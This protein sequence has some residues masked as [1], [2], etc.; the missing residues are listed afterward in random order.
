[1]GSSQT[2]SL[3]Q[4]AYNSGNSAIFAKVNKLTNYHMQVEQHTHTGR[5]DITIRTKSRIYIMELKFN[6]SAK[7]ALQ[8]IKARGYAE[9]FT[10]EGKPVT[11]VGVNFSLD[12]E[13]KNITEWMIE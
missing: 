7:E 6:A 5:I 1:M 13:K 4:H 11:K 8:Q 12:K 9:T 3:S 2:T 10:M